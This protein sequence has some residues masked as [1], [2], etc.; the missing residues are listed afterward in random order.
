M[1]T[2]SQHLILTS[3][4]CW[5]SGVYKGAIFHTNLNHQVIANFLCAKSHNLC[6]CESG[7]TAKILSFDANGSELHMQWI[8]YT[9]KCS[10]KTSDM[11]PDL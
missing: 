4:H 1:L 9:F 10:N 5:K 11:Y 2:N 7:K 8:T 3:M 6:L